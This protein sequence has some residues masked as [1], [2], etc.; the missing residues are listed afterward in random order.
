[1]SGIQSFGMRRSERGKRQRW[2]EVGL[3]ALVS[4]HSLVSDK[5]L[6]PFFAACRGLDL[7]SIHHATWKL[8]VCP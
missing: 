3:K 2:S 5:P 8:Q 4:E 6:K 7:W 1:M